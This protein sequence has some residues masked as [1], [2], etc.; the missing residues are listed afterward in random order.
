[1][2][3]SI[4]IFDRMNFDTFSSTYRFLCNSLQITLNLP[5]DRL[6]SI[7]HEGQG[8]II[9]IIIYLIVNVTGNE[10]KESHR[11]CSINVVCSIANS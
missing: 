9:I 7:R 11:V 5:K 3:L 4:Y 1:M 6:K 10:L 8:H 2:V